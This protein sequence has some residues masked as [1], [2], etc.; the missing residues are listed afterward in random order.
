MCFHPLHTDISKPERFTYP[1]F[2]VPHPLCRL[3]ASE[4]QAYI[5]LQEIWQMEIARGKMFG[6]LVVED[7][8]GQL[9]FLAAYSGLLAE[10]NDWPYFVP[11][12]YDLLKPNSYF[13]IHEAEITE[14]NR[15]VHELEKLPKRQQL[16]TSLETLRTEQERQLIMFRQQMQ[17]AKLQRDSR[18]KEGTLSMEEE[19]SL[20]HESQFM[21]AELRRMKKR[22]EAQ[23]SAIEKDLCVYEDQL[24]N[25]KLQRKHLSDDLQHWLFKQFRMLNAN[26]EVRDLCSIFSETIQGEP[27]AGAGECCAPKL[28][29]YAYA[30]HLHP[31]CMAEFWWGA[32]PKTEVRHHLHYYPACRSKCLP[33]LTHMLQGLNVEPNLLEKDIPQSLEILYE[34]A[35]LWVVNKPAGMLSVPGKSNRLSVSTWLQQHSSID[36]QPLVVHRLDMAT[37]GMLIVAKNMDVYKAL[38]AQFATRKVQKK[39]IALVD[40]IVSVKDGVISLPLRPDPMNRPYQLVDKDAGKEAVTYYEVLAVESGRTRLALHPLTGRTHQLRVHCAHM[41]GLNCPIVGDTLYGT[42]SDRLYLHA[43]SISFQH[44]VTKEVLSFEAL[45]PF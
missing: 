4:V 27:P 26:D 8:Q 37:S 16:L 10:R 29:Q 9:G 6:V 25:L 20:I 35:D 19:E 7:T 13:Q 42:S 33:I 41:E 40:G 36:V 12:V 39:Y 43:E 21:K 11:P 17:Q 23:R 28:L 24:A 32:S 45:P 15:Q 3:A 18:R 44:P 34:D 38:Q 14:L 30:H 2:Y 5:A 22:M 1:F 31:V